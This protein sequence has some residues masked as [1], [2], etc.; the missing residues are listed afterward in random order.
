MARNARC[1]VPFAGAHFKQE[2]TPRQLLKIYGHDLMV[3]D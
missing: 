2:L 3:H 1:Q